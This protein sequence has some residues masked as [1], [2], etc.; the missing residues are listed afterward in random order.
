MNLKG[1]WEKKWQKVS[2]Y[3]Y[4]KSHGLLIQYL[5]LNMYS[6]SGNKKIIHIIQ[7]INSTANLSIILT[8]RLTSPSSS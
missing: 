5:Y 8:P 6:V 7:E 2:S 1:S 4:R 3:M